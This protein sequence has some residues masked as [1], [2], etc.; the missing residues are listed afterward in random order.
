MSVELISEDDD[1]MAQ[2]HRSFSSAGLCA[3]FLPDLS[4]R[5]MYCGPAFDA[6]TLCP[7]ICV[8]TGGQGFNAAQHLEISI[9]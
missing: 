2:L 8:F 6:D 7:L 1:E 3:A 4:L 5:T 9:S